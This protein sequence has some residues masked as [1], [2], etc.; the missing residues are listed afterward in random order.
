MNE[1]LKIVSERLFFLRAYHG[2]AQKVFPQSGASLS[3]WRHRQR[4]VVI[5]PGWCLTLA[6]CGVVKCYEKGAGYMR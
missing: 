3:G 5:D 1:I 4:G 2:L 6:A